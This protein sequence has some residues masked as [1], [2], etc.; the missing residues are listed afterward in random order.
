MCLT[1]ANEARAQLGIPSPIQVAS[2]SSENST[3]I[4]LKYKKLQFPVRLAFTTNN[5]ESQS[6]ELCGLYLWLDRLLL[7]WKIVC[8]CC[9]TKNIVYTQLL[10][11]RTF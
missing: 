6:L 3:D 5:A 8:C 10:P 9:N 2:A 1:T 7:M 4:P 11:N